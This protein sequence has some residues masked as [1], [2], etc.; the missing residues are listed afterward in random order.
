MNFTDEEKKVFEILEKG[1][2]DPSC[3]E[4]YLL[5]I[6]T[7][8]DNKEARKNMNVTLNCIK[9]MII[10][11]SKKREYDIVGNE[12]YDIDNLFTIFHKVRI[13][14]NLFKLIKSPNFNIEKKQNIS[15][16][17]KKLIF[18]LNNYVNYTSKNRFPKKKQL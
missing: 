13:R 10:E 14:D 17:N 5:N 4:N 2:F 6:Y 15:S 18:S 8:D 12:S 9:R 11:L 7:N 16:I 1:Y 3:F